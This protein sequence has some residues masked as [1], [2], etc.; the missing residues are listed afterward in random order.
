MPIFVR[1][2]LLTLSGQFW[3][4]GQEKNEPQPISVSA[5]L[6][7]RSITSGELVETVFPLF[8]NSA[9]NVWS[10]TW[11]SSVSMDGRVEWCVYSAGDVVAAAQGFFMIEA[12]KANTA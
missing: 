8:M 7:Y 12:N 3:T 9:T 5:V 2:N 10:A 6:R 1:K 11:D 4:P